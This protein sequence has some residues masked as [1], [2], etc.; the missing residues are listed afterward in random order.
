MTKCNKNKPSATFSKKLS[1]YEDYYTKEGLS[2]KEIAE[3]FGLNKSSLRRRGSKDKWLQKKKDNAT[4]QQQKE[5]QREK[6]LEQAELQELTKDVVDRVEAL[7]N[8]DNKRISDIQFLISIVNVNLR[9]MQV[10]VQNKDSSYVNPK[11]LELFVK[12]YKEL[13]MLERLVD[14][15][16]TT[17]EKS[18]Q[19]VIPD[20]E[21][22]E[23]ERQET[24]L[25]NKNKKIKEL[26]IKLKKYAIKK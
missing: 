4:L 2:Y 10:L 14:G 21:F 15:Q 5:A 23:I 26:E 11:E 19:I 22:E 17:I 25:L 8:K 9:R 16:P 12:A 20:K 6:S 1:K 13:V 3:R 18:T 7:K 24:E